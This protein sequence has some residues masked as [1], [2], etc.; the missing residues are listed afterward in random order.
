MAERKEQ[1]MDSRKAMGQIMAVLQDAMADLDP[2]MAMTL[3]AEVVE[4]W[5]KPTPEVQS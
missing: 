4:E 2:D 5:L 3:V 1:S